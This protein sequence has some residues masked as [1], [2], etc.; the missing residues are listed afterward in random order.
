MRYHIR[1]R[2]QGDKGGKVKYLADMN[3]C[4][5]GSTIA[6]HDAFIPYDKS[7]EQQAHRYIR[8][9]TVAYLRDELNKG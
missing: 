6:N 3:R 8:K 7:N 2:K 1:P 9:Q 4:N 5:V